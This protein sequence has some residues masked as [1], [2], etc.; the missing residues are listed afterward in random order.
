[1]ELVEAF[2]QVHR[3]QNDIFTL[4]SKCAHCVYVY[5]YCL[6]VLV[7][8]L[9]LFL[10]RTQHP[11]SLGGVYWEPGFKR[12]VFFLFL[13]ILNRR[14]LS[15]TFDKGSR[16]KKKKSSTSGRATKALPPPP[17]A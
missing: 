14:N 13:A 6:Y 3:R 9:Y 4:K 16:K 2:D 17:R 12:F 5:V 15:C 11:K 1:M 10:S 8:G 7:K